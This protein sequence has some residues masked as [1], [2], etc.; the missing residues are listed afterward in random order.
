M[1]CFAVAEEK[2]CSMLGEELCV[3]HYRK[4]SSVAREEGN[5]VLG[6]EAKVKTGQEIDKAVV[7]DLR[8]MFGGI[9]SFDYAICKS[10]CHCQ[11]GARLFC[12]PARTQGVCFCL[13]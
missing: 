5:A 13:K 1:S 6:S 11:K 2:R 8:G 9:G 3:D 10:R 12:L 7:L 4:Q